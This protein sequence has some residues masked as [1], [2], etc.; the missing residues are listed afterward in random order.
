[1]V[2]EHQPQR[3]QHRTTITVTSTPLHRNQHLPIQ[4][5]SHEILSRVVYISVSTTVY[6]IVYSQKYL[7]PYLQDDSLLYSFAD[8]EDN[9][10]N[11]TES[12]NKE[13]IMKD[14]IN[15][16]DMIIDNEIHGK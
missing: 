4:G 16:D 8:D 15:L 10:D 14:L 1:M 2:S 12:V 9:E 3:N 13:E 11:F 5:R 6:M 7:K